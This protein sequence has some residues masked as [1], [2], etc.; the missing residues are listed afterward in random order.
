MKS[1]IRLLLIAVLVLPLFGN[2]AQAQSTRAQIQDLKQQMEALQL[3]NQQQMQQLQQQIELLENA[4]VADQEALMQLKEEDQDAWYNKFKAQYK[5]GLT[6]QAGD[7]FKMRFRIRG[8][9]RLTVNDPDDGLVSTNFS[10]ARL[11]LKWDGYAFKK[12]FLYTVQVNIPDDLDLRDAYFTAAYNNNIMPRV[13]QWKVPFGRDELTSS[14]A[15]QFI[16]RSIVNDEFGLGRD[17]GAAVMGGFGPQYNFSYSVGVFNGDG[18]NGSSADSNLLYAGRIQYGF[19]GGDKRKFKANSSYN[20]G[21]QYGIKPNFAKA[22]TFVIGAAA[23]TIP[24]L[25]CDRKSP[26]GDQ[27][28]R[29]DE[30]GLVQADMTTITGDIN[31]KMPIFN[32]QGGYYGRWIDPDEAGITQDTAYDQGFNVQAGVFVMPKTV[33]FAGRYSYIDY[34]TSSGV[35]PAD[36]GSTRSSTW[37]LAP[38]LNYYISHDHRWKI[39]A[40]YEF[41]RNEFT[42]GA[43]DEDDNRFSLQLQAYF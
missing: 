7:K 25:N 16:N 33:E 24:G 26:D 22:P 43:S 2:D 35:L 27:C 13:G 20:T 38:A 9:V 31:F 32:V 19:G 11:R 37:T 41:K 4:R 5:K 29:F 36:V 14:S 40:E 34:D 39:Q 1:V 6:F 12:W 42:Q 17:R 21:T 30:L 8:Q 28:D 15:L 18:R 23:S 10:I 3:Q